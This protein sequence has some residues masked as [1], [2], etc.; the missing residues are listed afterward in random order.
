[1]KRVCLVV[2]ESKKIGAEI[3]RYLLSKNVK[4][5]LSSEEPELIIALG[6]DGTVLRAVSSAPNNVPVLGIN[7]GT[8]GFLTEVNP[9]E[10]KAAIQRVMEG[11]YSIEKRMKLDITIE[12]KKAGEALNEAVVMTSTPVKMIHLQLS[13]NSK[14]LSDIRADGLIV[15]TPTGSTAYSMSCGGPIIDPRLE[16]ILI[17]S[18]CPFGSGYHPIIVP[19]DSEVKVKVLKAKKEALVV[20]DGAMCARLEEGGEACFEVSKNKA[21]FIKFE[22]SFYEKIRKK[23]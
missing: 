16:C 20:S 9:G 23:L 11:D 4:T 1:M 5:C 10:W 17:T 14:I 19:R 8:S 21:K 18:I 6:G 22:D 2:K 15:S 13:V 7:F 3:E 12:G